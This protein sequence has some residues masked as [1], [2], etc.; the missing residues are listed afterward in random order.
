M[1]ILIRNV[2]VDDTVRDIYIQG[3]FIHEVGKN[4]QYPARETIDGRGMIALPAFANGHTHAAMILLRGYADDMQL[5]EWL[6]EKIWPVESHLTEEDVYWGTRLACLEMIK[7]GTTFFN[8]MYWYYHGVARAVT[9]AGIRA[10]VAAVFIDLFD[11][12]KADD[13]IALNR[14]LLAET[15]RYSDRITFTLGPHAIYTVSPRSLRWAR[16]FADE[17]QLQIHIHLSETEHEVNECLREHGLRPV[18]YLHSI[19]FLGPDVV[20]AHCIWLDDREIDLLAEHGVKVIYNPTSNMKLS[21]GIFPYERLKAAGIRIGL[22]TDGCATNN[23]LDMLES[24]KFASLL[25]KLA[26]RNPAALPAREV[27]EL[28]TARTFS[29]FDLPAGELQA[30]NLA[31]LILVHQEHVRM[32]PQHDIIHNLVY[33]AHGGCIDTTICN[34]KILMRNGIVEGEDEVKRRAQEAALSLVGR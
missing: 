8:D 16:S 27:H 10:A 13:Q 19:G 11:D 33:A 2:L 15:Q 7:S 29:I 4:L 31:D 3:N 23:N 25:Q 12:Q 18:E 28:A 14:K 9:D 32:V 5:D 1:S 24:M 22:G 6:K 20:A 21:A 34:G 30:G 17:H 26:D